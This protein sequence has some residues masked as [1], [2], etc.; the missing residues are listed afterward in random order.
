VRCLYTPLAERC[1]TPAP[2]SVGLAAESNRSPL[3]FPAL[4]THQMASPTLA[5][6][7]ATELLAVPG[8]H[9]LGWSNRRNLCAFIRLMRYDC[10]HLPILLSP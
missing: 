2:F 1:P 8:T 7:P 5:P 9:T 4:G 6:D 10:G 3:A